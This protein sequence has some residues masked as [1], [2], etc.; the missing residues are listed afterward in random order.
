MAYRNFAPM[1]DFAVFTRETE[2]KD[3]VTAHKRLEVERDGFLVSTD[4]KRLDI[5]AIERLLRGSYWAAERPR[6]VIERSLRNSLCLG[7]YDTRSGRQIG[8]MRVATDYATFAWLCDAIVEDRYRRR[9][10]GS[11]M[12]QIVLSHP[13]V[14]DLARW[15]LAT[16]DAHDLYGRFGFTAMSHPQRWMQR[17]ATS[18]R[19][20]D[21]VT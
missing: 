5:D 1:P 12:M 8:F 10:L 11:W 20:S 18:S 9:G 7:L 3:D 14:R 6:D 16:R 21:Q 4:P 17:V 2:L 15:L 19:D 13:G